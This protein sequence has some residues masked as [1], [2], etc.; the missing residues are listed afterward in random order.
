[1]R[2]NNNSLTDNNFYNDILTHSR[3]R[4]AISSYHNNNDN[5]A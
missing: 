3:G 2:N 4:K 1:M 5:A